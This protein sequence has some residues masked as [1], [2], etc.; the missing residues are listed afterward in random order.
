MVGALEELADV[1]QAEFTMEGAA[2][3]A[4]FSVGSIYNYWPDRAT[5]LIDLARGPIADEVHAALSECQQPADAITWALDTGRPTL[6]LLGEVLLAGHGDDAIAHAARELWNT[7]SIGLAQHL[8]PSMAWDIS[9]YALGNALLDSLGLSGPSPP[10]G[11]IRWLT[12]ACAVEAAVSPGVS[13][14]P[15]PSGF[16][17]PVVPAPTRDDPT[18][19]ALIQAAQS[20]LQEA[21]V[22]GAST[23]SIATAAGVTTGAVYRRY[24]AK[25]QLF[26]DVLLV[27][28]SPD[29]YTWTWELVRAL[30]GDDPYQGAAVVM[31]RELIQRSLDLASQKVLLQIGIAARNDPALRAQVCQR[32]ETADHT[33]RE[34]FAHFIDVGLMRDDVEPAVLAWG[35]QTIPVGVR[36]LL[37]L[38]IGLDEATVSTA[39][40][41]I[42]VA[43]APR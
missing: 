43:T 41:A 3:R 10:T 12:D 4:F 34:M 17:V 27:E 21:G 24:S 33:R 42:L 35:F 36:A 8:P 26:A 30:A 25:S 2:R 28:L 39:M 31:T 7:V 1:G 23:R 9:V 19:R 40:T 32:I 37:P 29:R 5:L 15:E 13:G 18:T 38:G 6:V 14:V 20:I 22:E 11:R 16:A